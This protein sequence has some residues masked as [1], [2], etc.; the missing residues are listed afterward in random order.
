MAWKCQDSRSFPRFVRPVA[1]LGIG[2]IQSSLYIC[3]VQ[4]G[5]VSTRRPFSG[6]PRVNE[7]LCS[8]EDQPCA[9]GWSS[10][11]LP[12]CRHEI[13]LKLSRARHPQ[14]HHPLY[15][16]HSFPL[17]PL[18]HE[19]HRVLMPSS[20]KSGSLSLPLPISSS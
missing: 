5:G 10:I 8:P 11:P 20:L 3:R 14:L 7:A 15:G 6:A 1:W 12:P 17:H 16:R 4:L 19:L 13:I 9:L 18:R 2:K